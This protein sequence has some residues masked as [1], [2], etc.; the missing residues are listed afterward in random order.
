MTKPSMDINVCGQALPGIGQRFEIE[1]SP[2][3][4]FVVV[5]HLDGQRSIGINE[6]GYDPAE[7]DTTV[8]DEATSAFTG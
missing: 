7:V 5:A 8:L 3:R 4:Q 6:P 1:L 2:E